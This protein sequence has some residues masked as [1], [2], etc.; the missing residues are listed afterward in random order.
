L[1]K[2]QRF[3]EKLLSGLS[4]WEESRYLEGSNIMNRQPLSDQPPTDIPPRGRHRRARD[5]FLIIAIVTTIPVLVVLAVIAFV[6]LQGGL[7]GRSTPTPTV[8]PTPTFTPSVTDF[9]GVLSSSKIS[10]LEIRTT[11][12]T[13]MELNHS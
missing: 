10:D 12:P 5:R 13:E 9:R 8:I 3:Q 2:G 1:K 4:L 11:Y 6:P 7:L